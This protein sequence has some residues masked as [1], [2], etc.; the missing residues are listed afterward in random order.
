MSWVNIV[1]KQP[2]IK[3]QKIEEKKPLKKL[4]VLEVFETPE[5]I[6]EYK[7]GS[8]LFDKI[9]DI[10]LE[11]ERST[12]W[13]FSECRSSDIYHFF[14]QF[15]DIETTIRFNNDD[16]DEGSDCSDYSDN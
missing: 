16:I 10:K 14:K 8:E 7:I 3:V 15:I 5:E 9:I 13:Y 1:K 11:C 2:P 4:N 6:F 12:P